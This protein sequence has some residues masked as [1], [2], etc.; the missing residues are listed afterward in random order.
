M[1][2]ISFTVHPRTGNQIPSSP[3]SGMR[4]RRRRRERR[5]P[6]YVPG[7]RNRMFPHS[8]GR[9]GV[10]VRRDGSPC[11]LTGAIPP[12]SVVRDARAR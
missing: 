9:H 11:L 4:R 1:D 7:D 3:E 10:S 5:L 2:G 6:F 8:P 12:P